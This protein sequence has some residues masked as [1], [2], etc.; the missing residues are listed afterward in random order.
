MYPETAFKSESDI[1]GT[2][3]STN[4]TINT[5]SNSTTKYYSENLFIVNDPAIEKNN[6]AE[7][8]AHKVA[9]GKLSQNPSSADKNLKPNLD[10][11]SEL[12]SIINSPKSKN[13]LNEEEQLLI[14][15]FRY[16]L[17]DY[18]KGLEKFLYCVDYNDENE[19]KEA[20]SLLYQ[21]R[22]VDIDDALVLL[23]EEFKNEIIR[24]YAIKIIEKSSDEQLLWFLL[25]LV[26]ALRYE[27]NLQGDRLPRN[28]EEYKIELCPSPLGKFLITRSSQ[29]IE[30][31]NYFHWYLMVA[32]EDKKY[33]ELYEYIHSLFLKTLDDTDI[34]RSI[35]SSL[36]LQQ[37][38]VGKLFSLALKLQES[39]GK[40]A[41]KTP[42][43]IE[44]LENEIDLSYPKG[45]CFP[46]LP[47]I[48]VTGV[49]TKSAKVFRS[50]LSPFSLQFLVDPNRLP[51]DL[52]LSYFSDNSKESDKCCDCEMKF[53]FCMCTKCKLCDKMV[54]IT[55]RHHCRLCGSTLCDDDFNKEKKICNNVEACY[56]LRKPS[57]PV[58]VKLGDDVRQ[59]QLVI[60]MI[61][62]I[63]QLLKNVNLNLYLTPY[64]VIAINSNEGLLEF[65]RNS[66]PVSAIDNFQEFLKKYNPD[67]NGPYGISGEAMN[68][69][70][71]SCAGYCV[72]NY[73]LSIGDRHLDNIMLCQSG[74]LFHIDFGY[75]FGH[76]PK[77]KNPVAM[78]LTKEMI[79]GMGGAGSENYGKFKR[80]CCQAFL[81]LRKRATLLINLLRLMLDAGIHD[82]TPNSLLKIEDRFRLDLSEESA[83][84]LIYGI[85]DESV[86]AILPGVLEAFH[87]IVREVAR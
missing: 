52:G 68:I 42:K 47:S 53:N 58:M 27:P 19:V 85:I 51:V 82:L 31:A 69:Y 55:E 36:M 56:I 77:M 9:R 60:Q 84:S 44:L 59:D 24:E 48:Y 22:F 12:M 11:K 74:H 43:L 34:G 26:Q 32:M 5:N 64:R 45:V 16:Y 21:W 72:I 67:P 87:S 81:E 54:M 86:N 78:R 40:A 50:A 15:K 61:T 33:S 25:Q 66:L 2:I 28:I 41:K 49:N 39:G 76:D 3:I 23:T 1:T 35:N 7:R 83:E 63:D 4:N 10:E 18:K 71:R 70:V 75:V 65:V 57:F 38:F 37:E 8:K 73:L 17:I 46:L 14:W 62:L 30:I 20:I 80:F 29:S 13:D 6:P 79:D